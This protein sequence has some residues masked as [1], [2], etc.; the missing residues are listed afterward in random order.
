MNSADA[1]K[2]IPDSIKEQADRFKYLR[3]R[4]L[5]C[6]FVLEVKRFKNVRMAVKGPGRK[7][8]VFDACPDAQVGEE[9]RTNTIVTP[10]RNVFQV[11][12]YSPHT[13][14][15]SRVPGSTDR[16]PRQH[17]EKGVRIAASDTLISSNE[18][19]SH[20]LP[21]NPTLHTCTAGTSAAEEEEDN[22][23][24]DGGDEGTN[25]NKGLQN[26]KRSIKTYSAKDFE[27][28]LRIDFEKSNCSWSHEVC[29]SHHWP[30]PLPR[31]LL[32]RVLCR[33]VPLLSCV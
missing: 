28:D 19:M 32:L 24:G 2:V 27:K 5:C 26:R 7:S 25:R 12:L 21:C 23:D 18:H 3:D 4:K 15:A 20:P 31:H 30:I 29:C 14:S 22:D 16:S 8:L 33:K 11:T 9:E 6:S 10:D 1:Q 13:C 17:K